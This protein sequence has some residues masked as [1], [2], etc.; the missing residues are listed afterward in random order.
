MIQLHMPSFLRFFAVA[1]MTNEF[2]PFVVSDAGE[3]CRVLVRYEDEG[4]R[5][6]PRGRRSESDSGG[7]HV[8]GEPRRVAPRGR[9][10][11]PG[12]RRPY[13]GDCDGSVYVGSL[14]RTLRVSEFKA[15]VRDRNVQPLRVIWR[16]S[17]GYYVIPSYNN[18]GFI[19]IA[20]RMLY[21]TISATQHSAYNITQIII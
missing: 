10:Y 7:P 6:R 13:Y 11:R 19:C 14:P 18:N 21:Y 17:S 4:G 1:E 15:E 16:G 2:V 8:N 5:R 9:V 12:G 20:A 3:M